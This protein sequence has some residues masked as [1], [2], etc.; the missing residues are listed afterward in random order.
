MV[1]QIPTLVF[2]LARLRLVSARF[3]WRHLNYAVLGRR[4]R[5]G[6]PDAVN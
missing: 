2:V 1:F 6:S 4:G 3:L 5:R